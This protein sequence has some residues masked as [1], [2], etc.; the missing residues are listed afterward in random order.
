MA[1]ISIGSS[2][3]SQLSNLS[4]RPWTRLGNPFLPFA[5]HP[6]G[7]WN[8]PAGNIR[9]MGRATHHAEVSLLHSWPWQI[10]QNPV[11]R[12]HGNHRLSV[13]RRYNL[14]S[15]S[16]AILDIS[17]DWD[18]LKFGDIETSLAVKL[19]DDLRD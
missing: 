7:K 3:T 8:M 11:T 9:S 1:E 12:P 13:P 16:R 4:S 14:L 2:N 5:I 19:L 17:G 10:C 15:M 18:T 6:Q